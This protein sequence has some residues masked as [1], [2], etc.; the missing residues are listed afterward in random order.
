MEKRDHKDELAVLFPEGYLT[1]GGEQIEIQEY[2]LAQQLQYRQKMLPFIESLRQAL[3]E[4][5]DFSI[6][7]LLDCLAEQAEL[8]TELIALSIQR[9][10]EFVKNLRGE[11]A[12]QLLL[13]WWAVNSD[14]FTL[15]ALLPLVEK[16][17]KLPTQTGQASSNF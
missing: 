13:A 1:L 2:T 5:R 15:K 16:L 10:Q 12:E 11:E 4:E 8:V 7:K 9:P 3:G 6:D 14:F 17:S